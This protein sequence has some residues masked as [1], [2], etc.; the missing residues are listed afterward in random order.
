MEALRRFGTNLWS[1]DSD[2]RPALAAGLLMAALA[3]LSLQDSFVKQLSYEMS[4]WQFQA[5]RSLIN[6]A[7]ALGICA[8]I[9]R[10]FERPKRTWAIA[11]RSTVHATTMLFFF[12]GVPFLS[13]SEIAAGLYTYPFFVALLSGTVLGERVGPRRVFAIAVGFIG[14]LMILKPGTEAFRPVALMPVASGFFYACSVMATRKLCR[15]EQPINLAIGTALAFLV[16]GGGGLAVF[17]VWNPGEAANDWPYL[18]SGWHPVAAWMAGIIVICSV[19]NLISNVFMAKAYQSAESSW[20]AP[21]DYS[22]LIFATFWAIVI[23]G[24]VPDVLTVAGMAAVAASGGFVAWR[25]RRVRA[26]DSAP[27]A[28]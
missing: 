25:E 16:L 26:V 21:I 19:L 10:R 2:D 14:V 7:F 13:L 5:L 24:D 1:G 22:Y 8:L 6:L 28:Q 3:L 9:I 17:S 23:W 4:L 15:E 27:D 11:A 18:L 12:G 20:L